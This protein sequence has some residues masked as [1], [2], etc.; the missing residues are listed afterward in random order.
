MMKRPGSALML[1]F[2]GVAAP[3]ERDEARAWLISLEEDNAAMRADIAQLCEAL[4]GVRGSQTIGEMQ[5][6]QRIRRAAQA[7]WGIDA[8]P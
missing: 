2:D 7:R 8:A 3:H 1:T 6:L 5:R 4:R